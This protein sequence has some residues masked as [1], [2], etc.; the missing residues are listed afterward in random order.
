MINAKADNMEL[1]VFTKSTITNKWEVTNFGDL[2]RNDDFDFFL[3]LHKHKGACLHWL[4]NGEIELNS[5]YSDGWEECEPIRHWSLESV[6]MQDDYQL[7]IKPSKE[8]LWLA[9]KTDKY[10]NLGGCS[11]VRICSHAFVNKSDA[12]EYL[13]LTG[14]QLI[15][16]EV[17]V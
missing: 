9:V 3:C 14:S 16:I 17:E 11:K 1:V 13:D 6:F 10:E 7:R 12:E 2:V 15:E 5:Q 8:R 4:N